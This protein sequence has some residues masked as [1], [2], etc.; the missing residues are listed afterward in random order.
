MTTSSTPSGSASLQWLLVLFAGS[1]CAALIYE[2]V[3]FQLLQLVIGSSAISLG[4]VLG[5]YMGGLGLGS[6]ALPRMIPA[7]KHHPLRVYAFLEIGIG[8]WI[9][10]SGFS[11]WPPRD[12]I[13]WSIRIFIANY[14]HTAGFPPISWSDQMCGCSLCAHYSALLETHSLPP[15]GDKNAPNSRSGANDTARPAMSIAWHPTFQHAVS[16]LRSEECRRTPVPGSLAFLSSLRRPEAGKVDRSIYHTGTFAAAITSK[17]IGPT[18][19]ARGKRLIM[20]PE[21][22]VY[23]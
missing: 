16:R 19:G 8:T 5:V 4:L 11:T 1:G 13:Q 10:T 2:V 23:C 7:A 3:W 22:C 6:I 21:Y 9:A 15:P 17:S 18:L 14:W 20:P 12:S